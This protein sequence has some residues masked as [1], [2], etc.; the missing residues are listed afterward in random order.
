MMHGRT[1]RTQ[2]LVLLLGLLATVCAV[3]SVTT[4]LTLRQVLLNRLDSQLL[5]ADRRTAG[6]LQPPNGRPA[7]S[8]GQ[9]GSPGRPAEP[10]G[11]ST[12]LEQALRSQG[13]GTLVA[14]GRDGVFTALISSPDGDSDLVPVAD[15]PPLDQLPTDG[16]PHELNIAGEGYRALA[17]SD[18]DGDVVVTALPT[19]S[20]GSTLDQLVLIQL[21]VTGV[22]LLLAAL[23]ATGLIRLALRP[24]SRVATTARSVAVLPLDRGEVDLVQRVPAKDTDPHTEVGQ[25]GAAL[26]SLLGNVADA[27]SARHAS[28]QRLRRFAADASHELRTPLASIRGY[29]ELSRRA[30][31]P[32]PAPIAHALSRIESEA[33]RMTSLVEDLLLLAR[34]DAG[35]PLS[36][37]PVDLSRLVVDAVGDA[38]AA[39][40][41]HNWHLD[42][43]P[44]PVTVPGDQARLHQVVANLLANARTHT[45][46][47]TTITTRVATHPDGVELTVLD[48]GPGVP[49]ALQTEVFERF[50][51]GDTSRSRSSGSTGLG[52]AIVS[53]VV[54][55][56]GGHV[57][58]HSR[59]GATAFHVTL[60]Y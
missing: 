12:D 56:H 51:R 3:I 43:P 22:A 10:A 49:P 24:L 57:R 44:D 9:N 27:L 34:L 40:Q 16:R 26:N 17:R 38:R 32:V 29:A 30:D 42:L 8:P 25:V 46:A 13:P 52:L 23:A 1:L 31:E 36:V 11:T 39:G 7:D 18:D 14:R 4:D 47:G 35:R 60:P 50:S 20:V 19:A 15:L 21:V 59:P 55:A 41:D 53:A 48:D 58:L 2:V 45:P 6:S 33:V 5:Q 54:Q 28:E 37:D